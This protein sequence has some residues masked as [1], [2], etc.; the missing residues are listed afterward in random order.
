M[1]VKEL[2]KNV[3]VAW[4][5]EQQCPIYLAAG[6]AAQQIDTSFSSNSVLEL[7]SLNLSDPG[8]DL[9]LIG[10]TQSPRRYAEK[11]LK[12]RINLPIDLVL[13]LDSTK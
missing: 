3:N 5:P 12:Y 7:Y 1:K 8:Y 2:Q 13:F 6:T 4:S 9:E 10:T 11:Y